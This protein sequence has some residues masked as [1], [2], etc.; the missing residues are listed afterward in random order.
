M[1]WFHALRIILFVS[2][3]GHLGWEL[4]QLPLYTIWWTGSPAEIAFA[5]LHCTLGDIAI[6]TSSLAVAFVVFG[7]GGPS[8]RTSFRN[9]M[10]AT[11]VMGVGYTVFSEWLN[12]SVRGAWSYTQW[13]PQIPPLGTGL[14]PLLQWVFV[15]AFAFQIAARWL[16]KR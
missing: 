9:V 11:I 7:R 14:S 5:I 2:S 13:M 3:I 6:M 16:L 10:L 1:P 8:D 15:P 12:V 4:A